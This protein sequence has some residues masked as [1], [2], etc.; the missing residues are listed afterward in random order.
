MRVIPLPQQPLA[1]KWID[2]PV[3]AFEPVR[4]CIVWYYTIWCYTK[5]CNVSCRTYKDAA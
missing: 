1:E 3:V 2:E 5:R 4:D